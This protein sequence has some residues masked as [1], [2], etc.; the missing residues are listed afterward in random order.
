MMVLQQYVTQIKLAMTQTSENS[1][2]K[3]EEGTIIGITH[4][5]LR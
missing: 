4:I 3:A 1:S 5:T 2:Q